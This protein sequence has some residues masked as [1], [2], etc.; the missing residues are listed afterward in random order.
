MPNAQLIE[1]LIQEF[2]TSA[3]D[4]K[5]EAQIVLAQD[6]GL[7][8]DEYLVSC[9]K[10]FVREY[11][12]D[13]VSANLM[14][15]LANQA[16]L[17]IEL[18][19]SGI[20]D[21]LPEGM[22]FQ[23]A[24]RSKNNVTV[25]DM[26]LDYKQNKKKEEE[27][28]RFFLPFENDFFL[29]RIGLE[30]QETIL[31]EGIQSGYL[32]DYFIRFWNLPPSIPKSF[33]APLILLLP[34]AYKI[35]GDRELITES[36]EQILQEPIRINRKKAPTEDASTL[37]IPALGNADLGLN[38]VC[39]E[40]FM[41]NTPVFEIEI[42]PLQNSLVT[43]YLKGGSRYILMETFTRF[44]I[45]VGVETIISLV[46]PAEKRNMVIAKGDE[47]VLGYSSYLG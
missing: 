1:K 30:E 43:D 42:G 28:R 14:E 6:K 26:A 37:D 29:Q 22:F 39:G 10:R 12:R 27:I 32:N 24:Q 8:P 35:A 45:P 36:L 23:S 17:K 9:N 15:A 33:M 13:V 11:S 7:R 47:P 46:I 44:F 2:Q 19:R 18:S 25:A 40:V 20:Y 4:I 21:Q 31:L 3:W 38:F 34:Y 5:A 41:E 16:L